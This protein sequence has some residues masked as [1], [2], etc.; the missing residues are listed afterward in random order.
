MVI[1]A[2]V[3]I[4][5][6]P[7]IAATPPPTALLP[8]SVSCFSPCSVV[9]YVKPVA[10][11]ALSTSSAMTSCPSALGCMSLAAAVTAVDAPLCAFSEDD[12][13]AGD[14]QYYAIEPVDDSL[15]TYSSYY[16]PRRS[17]QN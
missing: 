9:R 4:P 3:L 6:R 16:R 7:A 5:N 11:N 13:V 8:C 14:G 12:A 17:W 1:I 2:I 15:L 10:R